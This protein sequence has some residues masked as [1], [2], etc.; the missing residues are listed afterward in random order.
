MHLFSFE[1]ISAPRIFWALIQSLSP[2]HQIVSVLFRVMLP[3]LGGVEGKTLHCA[4]CCHCCRYF[5][6][7]PV[8]TQHLSV[9]ISL[10]NTPQHVYMSIDAC[11]M[12]MAL[13][14]YMP[15]I[16]G[17][18]S[19]MPWLWCILCMARMTVRWIYVHDY[20]YAHTLMH[21]NR[22]CMAWLLPWDATMHGDGELNC[23]LVLR[24][25]RSFTAAMLFFST[26]LNHLF[27]GW[28]CREVIQTRV[29][30]R[31]HLSCLFSP[32]EG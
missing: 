13:S 27:I 1:E 19:L 29:S 21:S 12:L 10:R 5:F 11:W 18:H 23:S 32:V 8:D 31:W 15:I 28:V 17:M 2:V 24:Y 30:G 9:L 26:C 14:W 7:A 6:S 20:A 4:R 3:F 25:A 16:T 22:C